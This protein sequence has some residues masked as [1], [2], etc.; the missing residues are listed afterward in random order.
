MA[1]RLTLVYP[2]S[3][4]DDI[5]RH[6]AL[7][8]RKYLRVV[9]IDCDVDPVMVGLTE[10]LHSR[11]VL[12]NWSG[13]DATPGSRPERLIDSEEMAVAMDQHHR[14]PEGNRLLLQKCPKV[15]KT[16]RL[17]AKLR[18]QWRELV[19]DIRLLHDHDGPTLVLTRMR[20]A[21]A[22]PRQIR[23][24]AFGVLCITLG[25]AS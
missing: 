10:R 7:P 1:Q 14:F 16:A 2:S 15:G 8:E 19:K 9:Y 21:L 25:R 23:G 5:R 12:E 13:S 3:P 24:V 20:E 17:L 22:Q 18:G 6:N 4:L 11:E